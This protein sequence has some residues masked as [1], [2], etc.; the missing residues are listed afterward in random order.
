[1][2]GYELA[3]KLSRYD[4]SIYKSL[5]GIFSIN[6]TPK[7]IKF[8]QWAILNLSLTNEPGSH[9]IVSKWNI[10][11]KNYRKKYYLLCFQAIS[12]QGVNTIEVFDSLGLRKNKNLYKKYF[13]FDGIT[14]N[15]YPVQKSTSNTCAKFVIY[16]ICHRFYNEDLN[17]TTFM[18]NFF[19]QNNL[20]VDLKN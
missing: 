6:E 11:Q 1:M 10:D 7:D 17:F 18:E 2:K 13:K 4:K 16:Y 15:D 14:I 12:N 19:Y 20:E 5:V 3:E 9:W 8:H